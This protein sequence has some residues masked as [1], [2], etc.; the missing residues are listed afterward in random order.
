MTVASFLIAATMVVLSAA[1]RV[2]PLRNMVHPAA[3]RVKM[4]SASRA[5][6]SSPSFIPTERIIDNTHD[7]RS[8]D[9]ISESAKV[10][11]LYAP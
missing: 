11:L 1:K 8:T 3:D 7:K 6:W 4:T 5:S 9:G 2:I 10:L